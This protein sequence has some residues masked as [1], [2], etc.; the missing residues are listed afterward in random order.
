MYNYCIFDKNRYNYF[1]WVNIFF[2]SAYKKSII[3]D[4]VT[5]KKED[6]HERQEHVC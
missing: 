2:T 3:Y 1:E 6:L 5:G 4:Y